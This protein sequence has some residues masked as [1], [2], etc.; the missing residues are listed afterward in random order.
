MASGVYVHLPFCKVHCSYCDFPLTTRQSLSAE[1]YSAL[2][3]EIG[4]RPAKERSDTLYFGG[5]TPS[6]TP[7]KVLSDLIHAF[8]LETSAEITL[9]ANPDD[10]QPGILKEWKDLGINRLSI[11]VQ[12][13]EEPALRAMLRV[14]SAEDSIRA[15][16]E[17][18]S[19]GFQNLN[20]D[21]ILGAPEETIEGFLTGLRSLIEL[22]P[23]HFSIYFIELHERTALFQQIQSGKFR[24][25]PEEAQIQCYSTAVQLLQREGYQHYEV[26]N[27][28]L[29]GK[30]SCHNLKYWNADFY[31][32]YGL[33]AASY[34]DFIRTNNI[35]EIQGYIRAIQ[36]G[37]LPVESTVEE[38]RE[39]QMR[40]HIIFGMRKREGID[41]T[42]FQSNFGVSPLSLF[43]EDGCNLIES[44]MLEVS[45]DRLRLTFEGML[46]SNDI[47]SLVI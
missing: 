40:N 35:P 46:V 5:G 19:A 18:R 34:V 37:K 22:R 39:T 30:S 47:L 36:E 25:M 16:Q 7:A 29:P 33:G 6:L 45:G 43:P 4:M 2:F 15:I 3:K 31:Y 12:S 32:G 38:D 20:V 23:D 27:F 13:L 21:L 17:A 9:E 44:G 10:I 41:V 11:G 26:S 8:P 24:L 42:N 1:Y 28:S 14:H